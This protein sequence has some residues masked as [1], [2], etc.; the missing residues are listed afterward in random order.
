MSLREFVE[1]KTYH[2]AYEKRTPPS[3]VTIAARERFRAA[4]KK[5]A[6]ARA[7]HYI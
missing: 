2:L 4:F 6:V 3:E 5:A 7:K 1:N